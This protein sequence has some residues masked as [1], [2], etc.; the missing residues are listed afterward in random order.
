M[1]HGTEVEMYKKK[2]FRGFSL[3]STGQVVGV[4]LLTYFGP[5]ISSSQK[6]LKLN[7]LDGLVKTWQ[8]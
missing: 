8:C 3:T 4:R 6:N 2:T 5:N 1:P 7:L